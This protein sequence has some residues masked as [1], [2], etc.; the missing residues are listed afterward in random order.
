MTS[1]WLI[2]EMGLHCVDPS[3][4]W[5]IIAQHVL[6]LWMFY[7]LFHCIK[8]F[9]LFFLKCIFQTRRRTAKTSQSWSM[10]GSPMGWQKSS[11]RMQPAAWPSMTRCRLSG[12]NP[13]ISNTLH[14]LY[15]HIW[16]VPSSN[17]LFFKIPLAQS[18]C[19]QSILFSPCL[20]SQGAT[21]EALLSFLFLFCLLHIFFFFFSSIFLS[22]VYIF[23]RK[24]LSFW[25]LTGVAPV[26]QMH[27]WAEQKSQ[28]LTSFHLIVFLFFVFKKK[29]MLDFH[30]F[31]L[32]RSPFLLWKHGLVCTFLLPF[33][34]VPSSPPP[35]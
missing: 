30:L 7:D 20:S 1:N 27:A 2:F 15:A 24:A 28:V 13:T 6:N 33:V 8:I 11:R 21:S 26:A 9:I 22:K 34:F 14:I 12:S 16:E 5:V 18:Q 25:C 35:C 4:R 29:P 32:L 19:P 31:L 3:G 17:L 23:E 10:S